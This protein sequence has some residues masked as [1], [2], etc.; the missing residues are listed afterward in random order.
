MLWRFKLED[1]WSSCAPS[2]R[3]SRMRAVVGKE[4]FIEGRRYQ[5]ILK[6]MTTLGLWSNYRDDGDFG[7]RRGLISIVGLAEEYIRVV[8]LIRMSIKN[9]P[10]NESR[11][12]QLTVNREINSI[13]SFHLQSL[14]FMMSD[15]SSKSNSIYKNVR[16][17]LKPRMT[18]TTASRQW[19]RGIRRMRVRVKRRRNNSRRIKK[20]ATWR[21]CWSLIKQKLP[22]FGK[23]RRISSR[24][25]PLLEFSR[26]CKCW[27]VPN[28][29]TE[30]S[31]R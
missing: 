24:T 31:G 22:D 2:S 1:Q 8:H 6:S 7:Q 18:C 10:L 23:N 12:E 30:K 26:K 14:K 13:S 17:L 3:T 11:E 9:D 15:E 16:A 21:R 27:I 20:K 29:A 4:L 5:R 28:P 25:N 19:C